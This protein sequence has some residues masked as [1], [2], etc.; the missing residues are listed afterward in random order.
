MSMRTIGVVTGSRADYGIYRPVLNEMRSRSGLEVRLY[1]TGSHLSAKHGMT[2]KIIEDDGFDIA[3]RIE[4]YPASDTPA[5]FTRAVGGAICGF[6]GVFERERP[7]ILFVLGDRYEMHAA[8]CAA[9]HFLIPVAHA[10]GGEVTEGALDECFRHSITKMSHLHFAAT[11][12]YGKRIIRMGEEPWRVTV[13]G[14]PGLD[15]LFNTDF[16]ARDELGENLGIPMNRPPLMV[17]FHPATLEYGKAGEQAEALCAAL[18][19]F[20][21]PV[22]FTAPN[23]DIGSDRI[24]RAIQT[25]LERRPDSV[26][27]DNLGTRRYFSLMKY[28]A[29]MVGNSSSGIIEAASFELPV[30]NIGIRQQGRARGRNIVDVNPDKGSVAEGIGKVL[31]PEFKQSLRGMQNPY[32]DGHAAGR[33]ADVLESVSLDGKLLQKRFYD[34][35]EATRA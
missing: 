18:S 29:A 13:S 25:H 5:A 22:V 26:F 35:N 14:A 28:S 15:N 27:I 33:I 30:V 32:G 11:G 9:S 34:E 1:V 24:L 23:G 19:E 17:T 20:D 7:D 6:A 16:L 3:A 8:V 31:C 2:S 4:C 12:E 21:V 10:H